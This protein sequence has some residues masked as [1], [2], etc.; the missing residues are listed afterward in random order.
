MNKL[1]KYIVSVL[2]VVFIIT[3]CELTEDPKFLAS[4]NLFNDVVGAN[5]VLNGVYASLA[6]YNYYG[7]EYHHTLNWTSGLYNSHK[8]SVLRDI[9]ALNPTS[10]NKNVGNYW[11]GVFQTIS[12]SNNVIDELSNVELEDI[13]EQNNI[14]GQAYLIRA[15]SY[16]NIVRSFGKCPLVTEP[17]SSEDPYYP[18]SS[19]D[20]IYAQIIS[21]AQMAE[22]LLPEKGNN[23]SGRPAKYAANMLLAKVYMQLAGDETAGGTDN[24]QKAY[25]EAAKVYGQYSLV[26]DFKS[27]WDLK[28]MNNTQESIFEIQYNV[29]Y[30]SRLIVYWTASKVTVSGNNW[31]RF[32]PN[33]EVYDRHAANYPDDPRLHLT[34]VTEFDQWN[35]GALK[36]VNTYPDY[37]K[38]GSKDKSYPYGYKYFAKDNNM[39][40]TDTDLNFVIYRYADLLLMLAEIENELNGP[41]NAYQYVNEVLAR[42]RVAGGASS[43]MPADWGGLT[44]EDFRQNIMFEYMFELLGE[45]HDWFNVRRR[46]Y[47]FFKENVLDAHN[48][49]PDYKFSNKWD[50]EYVTNE[51]IMVLPI[52]NT[53]ISSNLKLDATDQNPGY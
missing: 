19:P 14:T 9:A 41:G 48:N 7:S 17:V 15:L 49:H 2:A 26:D 10:S 23:T 4:D 1:I 5:T 16:F 53:E 52:P 39:T 11:K 27:L 8:S 12:R 36:T 38:R 20:D 51:K 13:D 25:N 42:A 40:S 18:M 50:P 28:T 30:M 21:D 32:K 43:E 29:E 45:G 34:F 37:I 33:I 22:Q 3:A 31:A 35:K 6:G 47:T 44:Q 46:G 24:W